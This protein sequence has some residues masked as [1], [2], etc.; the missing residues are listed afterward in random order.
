MRRIHLPLVKLRKPSGHNYS[1]DVRVVLKILPPSVEYA[2]EAWLCSE[3]F[4]IVA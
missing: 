1:M 3:M 2:K 4:G